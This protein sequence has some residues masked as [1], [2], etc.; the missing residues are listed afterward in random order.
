MC[1]VSLCLL[2]ALKYNLLAAIYDILYAFNSQS[3]ALATLNYQIISTIK[4]LMID[5]LSS[6]RH[7][8]A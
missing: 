8:S 2:T 3:T 4:M 1:P 6:S 5:N 7:C